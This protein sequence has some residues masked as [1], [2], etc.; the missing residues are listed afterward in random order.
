MIRHLVIRHE[1]WIKGG[2]SADNSAN[3]VED[4]EHPDT[5]SRRETAQKYD[6]PNHLYLNEQTMVIHTK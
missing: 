3:K 6:A 4:V 1:G 5:E 2:R